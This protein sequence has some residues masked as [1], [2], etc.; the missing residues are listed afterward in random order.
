MALSLPLLPPLPPL[1]PPLGATG[2]LQLARI[3][4]AKLFRTWCVAGSNTRRVLASC[5]SPG[6]R[7]GLRTRRGRAARSTRAV[8]R[9][10]KAKA[11]REE[12][13]PA[14]E[15]LLQKF[16]QDRKDYKEAPH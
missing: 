12:Y 15:E 6:W 16:I 4:T 3:W 5:G 1:P 11:K 8:S 13:V 14:D 7:S 2:H 10:V 9:I